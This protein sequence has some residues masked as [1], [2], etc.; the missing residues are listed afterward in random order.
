MF[1]GIEYYLFLLAVLIV[2]YFSPQYFSKYILLTAS[3]LAYFYIERSLFAILIVETVILYL[4][5]IFW[6][7]TS[8]NHFRRNALIY[9][10]STILLLLIYF[11]LVAYS[12]PYFDERTGG[13]YKLLRPLGISFFTF[14]AAAYLLDIKNGKQK[15]SKSFIDLAVYISFFP[16]LVCGPIERAKSLLPQLI[17]PSRDYYENFSKGGFYIAWGLLLKFLV[18]DNLGIFSEEILYSEN[19][20]YNYL[21]LL[22]VFF[23]LLQLYADFAAYTLIAIGSASLLG[24]RLSENFRWPFASTSITDLWRRWHITLMQWLRDYVY[25]PI[26]RIKVL[27]FSSMRVLA[28]LAVFLFFGLWHGIGMNYLA[29]GILNFGLTYFDSAYLARAQKKTLLIKMSRLLV[30]FIAYFSIFLL[31]AKDIQHVKDILI[32]LFTFH[33][34]TESLPLSVGLYQFLIC[35]F[36]AS[37]LLLFEYIQ[38]REAVT[39]YQYTRSFSLFRKI[40]IY[41]SLLLLLLMFGEF[42]GKSFAY[43]GF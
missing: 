17:N 35:S 34:N 11:K 16:Q 36:V 14:Q 6:K 32:N 18:A 21:I 42:G 33:G 27:G 19:D 31:A 29:F 39:L 38:K 15:P 22:G 7:A 40:M 4:A 28:T 10:L 43:F 23:F 30:L 26:A 2:F 41:T 20:Y 37:L 5:S 3:Y 12:S 13:Y 8:T 24:I 25:I 9:A 1:L